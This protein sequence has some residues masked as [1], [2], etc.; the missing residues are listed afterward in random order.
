MECISQS[1]LY[2][3]SIMS[4]DILWLH[5][6]LSAMAFYYHANTQSPSTSGSA[7][8]SGISS[9]PFG[10]AGLPP[11]IQTEGAEAPPPPPP[12]CKAHSIC[13]TARLPVSPLEAFTGA[14]YKLVKRYYRTTATGCGRSTA[15]LYGLGYT[16]AK[17]FMAIRLFLTLHFITLLI[18]NNLVEANVAVNSFNLHS[19]PSSFPHPIVELLNF[20][21]NYIANYWKLCIVVDEENEKSD[22]TINYP[23]ECSNVYSIIEYQVIMYLK[24][25]SHSNVSN[26]FYK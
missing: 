4:Q 22:M 1:V 17:M 21:S 23:N 8:H 25:A 18:G 12:P 7:I 11:G 3:Y 9:V 10:S 15:R 5:L 13:R 20:I 14:I 16:M 24:I 26:V 19:S 6:L 2:I